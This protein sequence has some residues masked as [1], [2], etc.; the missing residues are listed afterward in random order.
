MHSYTEIPLSDL[1]HFATNLQETLQ[2]VC[3]SSAFKTSPKSC[4]FLRHIVHR[5]LSGDTDE[6]KER[7]I[8]MSLLGREATY[9]TGSDAGV[10]VRANDVRKRLA[11]Y[12]TAQAESSSFTFDLPS[13]SYVPRFFRKATLSLNTIAEDEITESRSAQYKVQV[14]LTLQQLAA[15]TVIALFLCIVCLRWQIAREHP[16]TAFW[17]SV[18]QSHSV[19]LY[20]P[21]VGNSYGRQLVTMNEIQM[22]APLLNLAGQFHSELDLSGK[23]AP[24]DGKTVIS[25]GPIDTSKSDAKTPPTLTPD[26]LLSGKGRFVILETADGRKIFDRTA[27]KIY[28]IPGGSAAL[29]TI[30]NGPTRTIRIDGTDESSINS[31]IKLLC[32]R[33]TFPEGLAD[34]FSDAVTTQAIFPM[35]PRSQPILFLGTP[36]PRQPN[37]GAAQ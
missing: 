23:A 36:R 5:T 1:P 20:L 4:E 35:D 37:I 29:L 16:F 6:L 30:S 24:G 33:N 28:S 10:R 11:A 32:E 2:A 26:A 34:S 13:G 31:L 27:S 17:Q 19:S 8:G 9:D 18:F 7:L 14:P 21:L 22:T 3:E 25:I 15:P 12:N